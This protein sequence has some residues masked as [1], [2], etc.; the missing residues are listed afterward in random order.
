[1][2]N[3]K[4]IAGLVVSIIGVSVLA[5][6]GKQVADK[7][8]R[9]TGRQLNHAALPAAKEEYAKL[10]QHFLHSD[11]AMA[12]RGTVIL[13]DGEHPD[14]LKEKSDFLSVRDGR[15]FYSKMSSVE[16]MYNGKYF[17]QADSVHKILMVAGV[18]EALPD[19]P[20]QPAI[21]GMVDRWFSDTASFKAAG[22][23][24]GD[25]NERTITIY[26]DFNPN[27]QYFTLRY[28][29]A[30]YS[31]KGAEIRFW[32]SNRAETDTA[33][34]NKVWIS[35][36]EYGPVHAERPDVNKQMSRIFRVEKH[37]VVPAPAYGD[38]RIMVK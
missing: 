20:A 6:A 8:I 37:T 4:K 31:V 1:M 30:D 23:V 25:N 35:R 18:L 27:I 13:Y 21:G 32:K 9:H 34:G 17:A 5:L 14:V 16:I 28:S 24:S 36:I 29:P 15:S 38:Y 12:I 2:G 26:S 33:A 22:A 3:T 19:N 7:Y 11:S 10:L